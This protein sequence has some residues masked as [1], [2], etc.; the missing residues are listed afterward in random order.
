[1]IFFFSEK[2]IPSKEMVPL[3]LPVQLGGAKKTKV[4][5]STHKS[6]KFDSGTQSAIFGTP[7][8]AKMA[9]FEQFGGYQNWHLRCPNQT[10]ETTF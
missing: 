3:F 9:L 1:M 6:H 4:D 8:T 7:K 5:Q 2:L 10:S